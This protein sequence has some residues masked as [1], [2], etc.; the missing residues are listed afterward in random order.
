MVTKCLFYF[1]VVFFLFCHCRK[2]IVF[3]SFGCLFLVRILAAEKLLLFI[4]LTPTFIQCYCVVNCFVRE[5]PKSL[6]ISLLPAVIGYSQHRCIVYWHLLPS[7]KLRGAVG[8][9]GLSIFCV[10]IH[11]L[12]LP[13]R[14]HGNFSSFL[15]DCDSLWTGHALTN[16]RGCRIVW[17]F[18]YVCRL[19]SFRPKLKSR[20]L[21]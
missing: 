3:R 6:L 13:C 1:V 5:L 10:Q 11:V 12:S 9:L 19:K 4:F 15:A 17:G 14:L 7:L 20:R 2:F 8:Q 21:G 18:I 16:E